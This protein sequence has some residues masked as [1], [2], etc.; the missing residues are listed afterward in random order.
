M[1]ERWFSR[2]IYFYV[3]REIVGVEF[4]GRENV[5]IMKGFVGY[6]L[7]FVGSREFL[8]DFKID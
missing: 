1:S 2:D 3:R 5:I 6:K 8:K 4:E 7:Y